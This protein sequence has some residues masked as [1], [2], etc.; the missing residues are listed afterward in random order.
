M[1]N[2]HRNTTGRPAIFPFS[3]KALSVLPIPAVGRILKADFSL[4][5]VMAVSIEMFDYR[6]FTEI[7]GQ[8]RTNILV[9]VLTRSYI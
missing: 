9:S 7:P 4:S 8:I 6:T 2:K 1:K 3:S 5:G